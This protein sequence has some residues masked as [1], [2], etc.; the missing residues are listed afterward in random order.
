MTA[1]RIDL[2]APAKGHGKTIMLFRGQPIGASDSQIYSA[3]RWLLANGHASPFLAA[4]VPSNSGKS[5]FPGTTLAEPELA[6]F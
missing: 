4:T 1:H 3:A 6:G 2:R 5:P